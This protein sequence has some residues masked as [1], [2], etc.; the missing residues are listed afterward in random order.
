VGNLGILI[1]SGTGNV[2]FD[3]PAPLG[4]CG[5]YLLF[6]EGD[7]YGNSKWLIAL[8]NTRSSSYSTLNNTYNLAKTVAENAIASA[9]N[10]LAL[11][12]NETNLTTAPA[13]TEDVTGASAAVA[14]AQAR[15]AAIDAR[16]SDRSIVAPFSGTITDVSIT[17]G[18]N[19]PATPVIT[20]LAE[21]AF[22]LKA[23]VPEIDITK[24]AIG[25]MVESIFDA[26]SNETIKGK[27]IY[28]SPIAT[29]IDGVAYF[30]TT[31]LLDQTPAWLRAGLNADIDII[32]ESKQQVLRLPKRFVIN[33]PES[34]QAVL[35][36]QGNK[37]ATTTIEV[38]FVGNDSF[39]EISGL[40]EGTVVVAP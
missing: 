5:L 6:N 20:V 27:V 13:R 19:A 28:V 35:I 3:Q 18:E 12:K 25:Q 4:E 24:I 31:I 8:P 15:I 36:P 33:L 37:T 16:I 21:N 29:Q 40:A 11:A 34:K 17:N 9:E 30:E 26:S 38:I 10:T 39:M 2:S 22:T 23:R 1:T 14:Q 7:I 32:S